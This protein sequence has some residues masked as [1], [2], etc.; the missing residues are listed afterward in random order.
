MKDEGATLKKKKGGGRSEFAFVKNVADTIRHYDMLRSGERVL[1]AVSGGPDSVAMLKALLDTR[2]KLKIEVLV[3]NMDHGIRGPESER[4]SEFVKE[5]S[6]RHG[7]VF[8]HKKISLKKG[9]KEAMSLEERAREER[10]GFLLKA[11][12]EAGCQAVA[13]GHTIDDQAETVLMRMISGA[14]PSAIGGIPPVR[15][16]GGIRIIRPLIRVEKND[17]LRFLRGCGWGFVE[18]STNKATDYARNK[19]RHD[20]IPFLEQYNPRLKRSLANLADGMREELEALR[21]DKAKALSDVCSLAGG[22]V[23]AAISDMMLQPRA[24]RKEIFKELLR[25]SGGNIKKLTYRHWMEA[26]KLLR[27]G[28]SGNSLDLPGNIRVTRTTCELIFARRPIEH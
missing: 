14:S 23:S 24:L 12:R 15:Y 16:E 18:D 19:V 10:Y 21:A 7:L 4:D 6:G 13:T 5:L 26:D 28:A 27:A 1:A 11:A 17:I 8:I 2:R 20:I 3:A 25:R 9:S 22:H